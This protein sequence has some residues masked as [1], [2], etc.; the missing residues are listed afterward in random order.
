VELPLV[1]ARPRKPIPD[2]A[3][4]HHWTISVR[5]DPFGTGD[6]SGTGDAGGMGDAGG[7]ADG[8]GITER[9]GGTDDG[10]VGAF[11]AMTGSL[12]LW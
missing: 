2:D 4:D 3:R 6:A 12:R 11:A 9:A 5:G 8:G 10:V 1:T 7:I